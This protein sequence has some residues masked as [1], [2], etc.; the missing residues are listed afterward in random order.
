[1][2]V[3]TE[4]TILVVDDDEEVL[5][6]LE[7]ALGQVGDVVT[8]T[9]GEAALACT[10]QRVPDLVVLDLGLPGRSGLEVLRAW[11]RAAR[12][13]DIT[14]IAM[15]ARDEP[16][17]EAAGADAAEA[18]VTKPMDVDVLRGLVEAMLAEQ[19][20]QRQAAMDEFRNL[21]AGDFPG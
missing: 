3:R 5:R 2:T 15:S 16:A 20:L 9:D 10:R 18:Y 8:V 17:D 6:L 7:V 11:R 4:P 19:A 14:V 12:T 13:A 1:M 21:Q